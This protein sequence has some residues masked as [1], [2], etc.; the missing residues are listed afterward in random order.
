[1]TKDFLQDHINKFI[2]DENII[3]KINRGKNSYKVNIESID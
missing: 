3:N 1:M 2:I